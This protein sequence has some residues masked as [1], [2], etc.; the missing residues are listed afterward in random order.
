ME[1]KSFNYLNLSESVWHSFGSCDADQDPL[2]VTQLVDLQDRGQLVVP[3]VDDSVHRREEVLAE[4]VH[5]DVQR[6]RLQPLDHA[7]VLQILSAVQC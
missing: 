6:Q 4:V 7:Q 2:P 3:D 5:V 1:L